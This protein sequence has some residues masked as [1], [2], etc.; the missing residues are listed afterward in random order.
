MGYKKNNDKVLHNTLSKTPEGQF[1]PLQHGR[2]G[3]KS[4]RKIDDTEINA[5]IESFNPEISHYRREHA[6]K[7]RYLSSDV[8]VALMYNDFKEK[9]PDL[10]CSYET[11]RRK[12]KAKRISCTKLGHEECDACETFKLHGHNE[13]AL[14][15]SCEKCVSWK[16]H[17]ER[18]ESS[19]QF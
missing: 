4:V 16:E 8:T 19:R 17:K 6:P 5:H 9:F 14:E 10:K 7:T 11:Y 1:T 12:I 3:Q 2:K 15:K 18:A 13:D